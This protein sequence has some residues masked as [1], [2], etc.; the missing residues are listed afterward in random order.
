MSLPVPVACSTAWMAWW[1]PCTTLWLTPTI[2]RFAYCLITW[3][4]RKP[5]AST[6]LGLPQRP[7]STGLR[8]TFKK[9]LT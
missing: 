4:I 6:R 8:N 9:T 3:P 1:V 2:W 5:L 7:V